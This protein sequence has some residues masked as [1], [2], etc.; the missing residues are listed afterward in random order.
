MHILDPRVEA[1]DRLPPGAIADGQIVPIAGN[2]TLQQDLLRA[3]LQDAD[4]FIA[5]TGVDTRNA[6]ASQMAKHLYQVPTVICRVDDP[7]IQS[8]YNDLGIVAISAT[9]FVSDLVVK[10][11]GA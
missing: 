1:F 10:A 5:L 8:M 6:L 3:S 9:T 7:T 2:G 4:V 11:T